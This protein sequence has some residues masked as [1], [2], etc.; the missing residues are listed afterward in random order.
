MNRTVVFVAG[1]V[2]LCCGCN[3]TQFDDH[4]D[5]FTSPKPI[6][7][8]S[9]HL[10]GKVLIILK[11]E[12]KVASLQAKLP[13][14]LQA[15]SPGDVGT[16]VWIQPHPG[17]SGLYAVKNGNSIYRTDYTVSVIDLVQGAT[18]DVQTFHGSISSSGDGLPPKDD[19]LLAYLEHLPRQ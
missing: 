11:E 5:E 16:V 15:V 9:P 13:Q 14:D 6:Q 8:G 2:M 12:R 7:A 18:V 3:R 4:M 19:E 1:L 17:M 10:R